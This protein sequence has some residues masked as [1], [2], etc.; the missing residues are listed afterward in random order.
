M[1]SVF[2]PLVRWLF[3]EPVSSQKLNQVAENTDY[4]QEKVDAPA[5]GLD[6]KLG[7]KDTVTGTIT[8]PA[9]A[10]SGLIAHNRGIRYPIIDVGFSSG[11]GPTY[12]RD[13]V[14]IQFVDDNT[15]KIQNQNA[16]S[17]L[18]FRYIVR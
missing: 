18:E 10:T 17:S 1:M 11:P 12:A 8:I 3:K 9:S 16:S 7:T 2:T 13:Y 5:T 14:G 6:S 4:L 15:F